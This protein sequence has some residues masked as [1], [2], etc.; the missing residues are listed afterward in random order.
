MTTAT[1]RAGATA[2]AAGPL[3]EVWQQHGPLIPLPAKET[4]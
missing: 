4:E 1:E 2:P 3:N